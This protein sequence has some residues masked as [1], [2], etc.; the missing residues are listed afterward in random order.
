VG[1]V[2]Y[3]G[4]TLGRRGLRLI[5]ARA[6]RNNTGANRY[7][8][9]LVGD[10]RTEITWC[11]RPDATG[12]PPC[13]GSSDEACPQSISAQISISASEQSSQFRSARVYPWSLPIGVTLPGLNGVSTHWI[14]VVIFHSSQHASGVIVK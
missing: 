2:V 3:R 8:G 4:A 1:I 7:L 11:R 5:R 14:C 13:I 9:N 10:W 12:V 6:W